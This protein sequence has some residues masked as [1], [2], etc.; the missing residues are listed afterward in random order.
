M[1]VKLPSSSAVPLPTTSPA[2][3]KISIA[4]LAVAVPVTGYPS[5]LFPVIVAVGA[6]TVKPFTLTVIGALGSLPSDS[7]TTVTESPS[8]NS[9]TVASQLPSSSAS[10][11]IGSPSGSVIVTVAPG[12]AV[13]LTVVSPALTGSIVGVSVCRISAG[14]TTGVGLLR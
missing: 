7:A 9:G 1:I 4:A 8:D 5:V 14:T 2:S 13:P 11:V 10:A 3:F 12:S 6:A